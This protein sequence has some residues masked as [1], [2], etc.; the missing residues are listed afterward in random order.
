MGWPRA[1][2]PQTVF[3]QGGYMFRTLI[4]VFVVA[5]VFGLLPADATA[6]AKPCAQELA[7]GATVRQAAQVIACRASGRRLLIV[8]EIHGTNEPPDLAA[9]LMH[10]LLTE[11]PVRLG[12]ELPQAAQP[13]LSAYVRS[14][15]TPTDTAKLL[16]GDFW[17]SQDGRSSTAMLRLIEVVRTERAAGADVDVFAME[18][19]YADKAAVERAGGIQQF[20]E[21]GI[22]RAIQ[23]T[24]SS[25]GAQAV[26]V[27]LMGN[28][29]A[30]FD[31]DLPPDGSTTAQLEA[32]GP[33]VVLPFARDS[34]AWNCTA[35]GC[36]VHSYTSKSAPAGALP[37]LV[38]D[39]A[40]SASSPTVLKLWLPT[41]TAALPAKPV[42]HSAR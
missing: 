4:Q 22:A 11:H 38:V 18:P 31:A 13:A 24:S 10:I 2:Y 21:A 29:H 34:S 16:S 14:R 37:K 12:I 6:N 15:G 19:S 35:E 33:F 40:G 9:N 42:A 36:G 41:A 25:S 27:A 7:A 17:N 3:Q 26:V 28:V 39:R 8:G 5:T 20:K 30:R 32:V 1:H 23:G